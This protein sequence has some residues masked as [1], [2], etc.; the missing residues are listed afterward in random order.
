[1][2]YL[3]AKPVDTEYI[4]G[5]KTDTSLWETGGVAGEHEE[6]NNAY[7]GSQC[8]EFAFKCFDP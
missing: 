2:D 5:L 3:I 6:V 7:V 8:I 4:F 1:M